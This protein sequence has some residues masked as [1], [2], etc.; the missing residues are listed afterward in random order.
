MI[1]RQQLESILVRRFPGAALDQ[2][3]PPPTPSWDWT[4][5][6]RLSAARRPVPPIVPRATPARRRG[7]AL[8]FEPGMSG[9]TVGLAMRDRFES[10]RC[11]ELQR[12]GR[13]KLRGLTDDQRESVD[14]ITA[15]ITRA[16]VS[17]AERGLSEAPQ[18]AIEAVARLFAL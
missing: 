7:T 3:P 17:M 13:R 4:A 10:I 14:T 18:L 1:D 8:A 16:I 5:H 11:A 15:E 9:L 2:S 6:R 12:L